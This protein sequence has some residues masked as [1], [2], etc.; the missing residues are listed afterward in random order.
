VQLDSVRELKESLNETIIKP[1]VAS[2]VARAAFGMAAQPMASAGAAGPTMA[3]GVV[4]KSNQNYHLAVRIQRRGLENSPQL[5]AIKKKAKNEVDVRYIGRVIKFA[6]PAQQKRSRP[7]KIGV[8][9]GHFKITAGTFGCFVRGLDPKD[10]KALMILSNNHVLANENRARKGDAILQPGPIDDGKDPADK[11]AT[12]S[13]FVRLKKTG[14]NIV[15]VAVAALDAGIKF[16]ARSLAGLG[17]SLAGV[18][19]PFLDDGTPVAKV[20]RTTATTR[21]KVTAFELDNVYVN[22][23]IGN[24]RFDNQ[25]EIEGDGNDPFSQGG[26]SGS[27]I[28]DADRKAVALLFAGGDVGGSN[29]KGLTYANPIDAILK[30]LKIEL[31]FT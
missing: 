27:L 12:L 8:S 31:L 14:A 22:Y 24:L 17:G 21:G 16:N 4:R 7:L 26:D 6:T 18:G 20:G 3:L 25:V 2:P 19:E 1:M 15:D 29:G 9:V 10:D 11:V 28:V 13:R 30:A 5:D 23:D